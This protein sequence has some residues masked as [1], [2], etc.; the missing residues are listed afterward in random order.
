MNFRL[1]DDLVSGS[2]LWK[3]TS[4]WL[5][6]SNFALDLKSGLPDNCAKYEL[7]KGKRCTHTNE[8]TYCGFCALVSGSCRSGKK[9]AW[10]PLRNTIPSSTSCR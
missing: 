9:L 4:N 8:P 5:K 6:T 10:S 2:D 7:N 1:G 3:S